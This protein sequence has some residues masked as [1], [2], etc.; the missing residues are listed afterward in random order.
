MNRK[1][2]AI[3]YP[4]LLDEWDYSKNDEICSPEEVT[5]GSNKKVWW[6]CKNG[7][8]FQ[9]SINHRTTRGSG[10]PYCA[11]KKVLTGFNDLK[12]LKPELVAEW[13]YDK[14]IDISPEMISVHSNKFAWW[15]CLKCG[16]EWR[17][18]IETRAYGSVCPKCAKKNRAV[19]FR[20]STYLR[21][22]I[23]DLETLRPDLAQEWDYT[24]NQGLR[25]NDFTCGSK[26]KVWWRCETCGN[27]WQAT[28]SNRVG[29]NSGCPKCMKHERTSFPEQAL[30][31]YI[32][33]I[34]PNAENSYTDIF[35]PSKRELDIFIPDINTGI[36][37]DGI[38][39]HSN[40]RS[41][42]VSREKYDVCKKKSIKLIRVSEIDNDFKANCDYFIFRRGFTDESLDNAIS[43]TLGLISDATIDVDVTRDR[44]IIVKQFISV[45]KNKSI[46]IKC[47]ELIKEWDLE[48]NDGITPAMV[49]ANS[50]I[51]YWWKCNLGHSFKQ[52][53]SARYMRRQGCPICSGRSVLSGFNDLEFRYPDIAK[54]W[55]ETK[56]DGKKPSEVAPG[57]QKKYWWKCDKGHSY[58]ATPNARTALHSGCP[59]C[60][61]Q[62][63][64]AGFNDLATTN[65][66]MLAIWDYNKNEVS[67]Q[68]VSSGSGKVVW[69]RCE[70]GHSWERAISYQVQNN[71][72]PICNYKIPVEGVNDLLTTDP[73]LAA[74]WDYDKNQLLPT[75][76]T[77]RYDKHVWWKCIECGT[78]WKQKV[79]TRVRVGIG[80][81]KCG[82][83]RK[84]QKTIE[85]RVIKNEKDLKTMFPEI[86]AEWDYERNDGLDPARISFGSNKKGW[87]I[88]PNGHHYEAWIT[89]RTGKKK[90]GCPYCAQKRI[91]HNL[92]ETNPNLVGEW[93]YSSNAPLTPMD[94]IKSSNQ[95]V[96]WICP[97][98]H[99]YEAI[100]KNRANKNG[101]GCPICAL[102]NRTRAKHKAIQ[103][104]E[105]GQVFGSI[106][107]AIEFVG[108]SPGAFTNCLKGRTKTA[109]GFHWKYADADNSSH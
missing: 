28:I 106:K 105:T 47:P 103:C 78:S 83:T 63:V 50:N 101:T 58:L 43:Q 46:A 13:D 61:G 54:E 62:L 5:S 107:E 53:P 96:W 55:D 11:G 6:I 56:N 88:C 52:A 81:P 20:E 86:A 92:A 80:C 34:Y 3:E 44:N 7:H 30:L 73:T 84:M 12:T 70:K 39:W 8:S 16:N 38:A 22:G 94:V 33:Q 64:L 57:S 41:I 60:N 9:Q 2:L 45:I 1:P 23:N 25:P 66:E 108:G 48:K 102:N 21:R 87:W 71:F 10:C 40:E 93:D 42:K 91:G 29:K 82:Y 72:C 4:E 27:E 90:T 51:K 19:S 69:W 49:N 26:E 99:H 97:N 98:G 59:Y 74:E 76:I 109:A 15:K 65:S 75:E 35:Y 37:Y 79:S 95:K 24:K 32:H 100:I 36:E 104:I 89:D 18:K 68:S 17:A 85:A 14:N 31:F 67:P 77:R